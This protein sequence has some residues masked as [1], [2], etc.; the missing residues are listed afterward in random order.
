MTD[1]QKAMAWDILKETMDSADI[2]T[3]AGAEGLAAEIG[4]GWINMFKKMMSNT[5]DAFNDRE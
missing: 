1:K 2:V 4:N 5:E 3:S